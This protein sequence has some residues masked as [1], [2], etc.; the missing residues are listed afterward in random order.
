MSVSWQP[1]LYPGLFADS[2]AEQCEL[3]AVR[4]DDVKPRPPEHICDGLPLGIECP[5]CAAGLPR[6]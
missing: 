3:F 5:A 2:L 6:Q 1:K 4:D